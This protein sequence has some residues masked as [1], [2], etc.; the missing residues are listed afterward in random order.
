MSYR[1]SLGQKPTHDSTKAKVA[2]TFQ[3]NLGWCYRCGFPWS[4]VE[5]HSTQYNRN[6]ACFPLCEEC[7]L[8]LEVPEARIEYYKMLIDLWES[9]GPV[10]DEDKNDIKRAVANGG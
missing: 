4:F 2:R 1:E 10:S 9:Q 7:W 3:P 5:H 6:S 8:I